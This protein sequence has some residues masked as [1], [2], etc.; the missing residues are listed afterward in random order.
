MD[1]TKEYYYTI[2][3]P[4]VAEFKD[5]GSRFIAYAYPISSQEAFKEKLNAI[6]KEHPKATHH[7]FAYRIGLGKNIFRVSDDGEP[8]GSAGKPILGQIDSKDLTDVVV[9]VVR[10]FGGTLLGVP[11]LINAYK[12]A[13]ALALQLTPITMKSITERYTLQFD[14]TQMNEVMNIIRTCQCAVVENETQLFC[15]MVV[16]V[17]LNRLQEFLFKVENLYRVELSKM[18]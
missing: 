15:K 5:R 9:F 7:C 3:K 17:P 18:A 13:T 4:A 12:T 1:T 16:D 11:G 14:Y 6:K 8:S 2:E 10:Y